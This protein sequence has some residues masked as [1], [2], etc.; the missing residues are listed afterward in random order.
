MNKQSGSKTKY[1]IDMP[2]TDS[3]DPLI[4]LTYVQ[5]KKLIKNLWKQHKND[6]YIALQL[7]I[8]EN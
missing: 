4:Y 5:F 3:T 1:M 2:Q 6:Q 7:L 8:N